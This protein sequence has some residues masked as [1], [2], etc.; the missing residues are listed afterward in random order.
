MVAESEIPSYLSL[1]PAATKY[2]V[3][4][5]VEDQGMIEFGL[6]GQREK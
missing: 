3:M 5:S 2:P 4:F 1:I 6:G